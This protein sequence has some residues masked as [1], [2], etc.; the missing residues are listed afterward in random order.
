MI[1]FLD[2]DGV[3]HPVGGREEVFC[4]LPLLWHILEAVPNADVVFSTSWRETFSI[5]EMI[6]FVTGGEEAS[7]FRSRF[8]G[9]NPVSVHRE[10]RCLPFARERE[11][12]LWLSGNGY[13]H[14]SWLAIDDTPTEFSSTANVF[15]VDS[16]TGLTSADVAAI[17]RRINAFQQ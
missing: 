9:G 10:D 7:P 11:C 3:L 6:G 2:F 4:R 16:T 12:G 17:V 13:S 15:T 14:H 8:T 1:L 5:E